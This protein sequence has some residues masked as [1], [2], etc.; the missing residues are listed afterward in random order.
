MMI[1]FSAL[2]VAVA[3]AAFVYL[4]YSAAR[5]DGDVQRLRLELFAHIPSDAKPSLPDT[6]RNFALKAGGQLGAPTIIHARHKAT[7]MSKADGEEMPLLADQWT[8]TSVSGLVWYAQARMGVFPVAVLDA[9]VQEK[10][11]LAV[12]LFGALPVSGGTG[13]DFDKGEMMR[14]LSELPVY[15]DAILNNASLE[16]RELDEN[17]V[18][19]TG[20]G[21]SGSATVRFYFDEAGDIVRMEADDRPMTI[22]GGGTKPTPWHGFYGNYQNV[23]RYRIP[24]YGEVG[25]LLPDGL[26][27]YWHGTVVSYE[28]LEVPAIDRG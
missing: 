22:E 20:T 11:I 14:Y 15:P 8:H 9:Y 12:R 6:V 19:V 17:T 2:I 5:F 28:P 23:G 24:T 26:F 16:W 3:V 10:G 13:P 27:T 18:E 25:W 1:V 4:R 7:L 21:V